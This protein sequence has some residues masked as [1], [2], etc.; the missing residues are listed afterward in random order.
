MAALDRETVKASPLKQAVPRSPTR[1]FA[2]SQHGLN[3]NS[4]KSAAGAKR[5]AVR[6]SP[7]GIHK[8]A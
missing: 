2:Q 5:E 3:Q 8:G 7:P 1:A 4:L 6:Q